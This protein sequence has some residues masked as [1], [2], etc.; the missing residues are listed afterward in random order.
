M[1]VILTIHQ[2]LIYKM[3]SYKCESNS[4]NEVCLEVHLESLAKA[5]KSVGVRLLSA[6]SA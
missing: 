2:A 1:T 5:L 4:N 6:S 3:D